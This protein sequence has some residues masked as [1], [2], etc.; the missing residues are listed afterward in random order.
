VEPQAPEAAPAVL[1]DLIAAGLVSHEMI[2]DPARL[3][4]EAAALRRLC[5][6]VAGPVWRIEAYHYAFRAAPGDLGGRLGTLAPGE[7]T[8]AL[9]AALTAALGEEAIW[10]NPT[11]LL[12]EASAALAQP[13]LLLR[14]HE[15]AVTAALEAAGPDLRAVINARYAGECARLS[16]ATQTIEG[17]LADRLASI[18][19][20]QA[21]ILERLAS[22]PEPDP[23]LAA[24]TEALAAVLQRLDAQAGVLHAHIAREDEVATRLADLADLAGSPAAFQE[25]L[26]VT[27]AEFLAR[28]ERQA[29]EGRAALRVPQFS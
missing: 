26:G 24:L 6:L 14:A 28:I 25:T 7:W 17:P 27:F 29:E 22:V 1:A 9:E 2:G 18:E 23:A 10:L 20:R 21:E 12:P 4:G 13:L 16:L 15:Q 8:A 19:A 5:E 3:G 11:D